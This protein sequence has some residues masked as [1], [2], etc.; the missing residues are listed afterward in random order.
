MRITNAYVCF[1]VVGCNTLLSCA[2]DVQDIDRTQ[3]NVVDKSSLEGEWFFRPTVVEVQHNQGL[4]FEGMEGRLERIR[5]EIRKDQL[6]AFR[7]WELLMSGEG[8][9]GAIGAFFF[10]I[11]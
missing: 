7:S 8:G 1:W 4:T 3:P 2:P 11:P 10:T 6:V 5:F 9:S